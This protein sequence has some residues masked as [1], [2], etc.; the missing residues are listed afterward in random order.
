MPGLQIIPTLTCALCGQLIDFDRQQMDTGEVVLFGTARYA[1]CF[2]CGQQVLPP[3]TDDYKRRWT[4]A[5]RDQ[6]HVPRGSVWSLRTAFRS[7]VDASRAGLAI[8]Q[9]DL[10]VGPERTAWVEGYLQAALCERSSD[11]D[12]AFRRWVCAREQERFRSRA[13]QGSP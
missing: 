4:Q 9:C 12:H 7:G 6:R 11:V 8:S 5:A 13:G 3:W 1:W 10:P 2:G